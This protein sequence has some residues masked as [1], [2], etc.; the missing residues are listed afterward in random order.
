LT[1][2]AFRFPRANTVL[3]RAKTDVEEVQ[4]WQMSSPIDSSR[5][6]CEFL[7]DGRCKDS[8]VHSHRIT[9][10]KNQREDNSEN[11]TRIIIHSFMFFE[12]VKGREHSTSLA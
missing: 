6:R 2:M 10:P 12:G 1:Q 9:V 7:H 5:R 4:N 8:N 3:T 11:H